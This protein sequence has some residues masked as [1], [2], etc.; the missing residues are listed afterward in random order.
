M[1]WKHGV[2]NGAGI[3]GLLAACALHEACD[4]VTVYD[5]DALPEGPSA[6][7]GVPQGRQAHGLHARGVQALDELLPGFRDEMLAAGGVGADVQADVHWYLDGRLLRSAPA[8]L[9]GI[10]M[11][12][13]SLER[14]IRTRVEK[15]PSVSIIDTCAVDGLVA[16]GGRVTGVRVR[17]GRGQHTGVVAADLVVEAAGRGSR[18]PA[19]LAEAG[20]P[21][22]AESRLEVGLSYVTRHYQYHDGQLDGLFAS[23]VLPH[24]AAHRGGVLMRQDGDQWVLTLVG[25]LGED[26][27]V[28]EAGMLAYAGSLAGPELA[29]VMRASAPLDGPVKMRFPA[30]VRRHYDRLDRFPGGLVVL[31][32]ALG[33]FN[34]VYAQGMTIAALEALALRAALAVPGLATERF[35]RAAGVL[36]REA[37]T[38]SA[39]GDLR[40]PEVAGPRRAADRL[41]NAY[42]TR[43]R[44]GATVDPALGRAFLRVVNMIDPPLSLLSPP[45]VAR[46]LRAGG[47]RA[48]AA[49]QS[50]QGVPVSRS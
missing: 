45:T 16:E 7:T 46:V 42:L 27:P 24:P 5:Q 33:S 6:R 17:P 25:L 31:G 50:A 8:G 13:R 35:R 3:A 18:L 44:A 26:P 28:D 37:W 20:Y 19:W 23:A 34:P 43:L 47:R 1:D 30:S 38:L 12:R 9:L 32:D 14:L 41:A 11:T 36:V 4:E 15:L 48:R 10:G 49:T 22:P 29:A 2:V 21:Q 40:F 39:N